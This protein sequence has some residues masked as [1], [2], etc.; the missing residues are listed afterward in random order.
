MIHNRINACC[1]II[2]HSTGEESPNFGTRN[3]EKTIINL[4]PIVI[5]QKRNDKRETSEIEEKEKNQNSM[6]MEI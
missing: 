4:I 2:L 5:M 1:V 3:K 6:N